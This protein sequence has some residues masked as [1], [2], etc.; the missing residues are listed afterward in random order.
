MK[1]SLYENFQIYG[2]LLLYLGLAQARPRL[3]G[4]SV[5]AL[6]H[7]SLLEM[8]VWHQEYQKETFW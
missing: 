6:L 8:M 7:K 4:I 5:C 1:V 3:Y 2:M